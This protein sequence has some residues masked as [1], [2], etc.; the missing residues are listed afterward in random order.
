[1]LQLVDRNPGR[2]K[3]LWIRPETDRR[4]GICLADLANDFQ[5]AAF[6]AAR[7]TQ[8][9]FLAI[10]GESRLQGSSTTR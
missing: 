7:K 9:V 10:R 5:L 8:V 1:M 2:I 4:T 3:I 6:L